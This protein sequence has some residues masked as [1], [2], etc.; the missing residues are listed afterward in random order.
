M[1]TEELEL[2]RLSKF[3]Y[4][5]GSKM[6]YSSEFKLLSDFFKAYEMDEE[7]DPVLMYNSFVIVDGI[8][9]F[10]GDVFCY[11]LNH[12]LESHTDELGNT[13]GVMVEKRQYFV[14]QIFFKN[15]GFI[16]SDDSEIVLG[17]W[18]Q[19]GTEDVDILGDV[20]TS[21]ELLDMIKVQKDPLQG[22][23]GF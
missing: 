9:L 19:E 10:D 21:P 3:R 12:D 14:N 20:Y 6:I 18:I 15:G 11:F 7:H 1:N 2:R 4:W 23:G 13:Y 17:M 16:V 22:E 5:N 8:S